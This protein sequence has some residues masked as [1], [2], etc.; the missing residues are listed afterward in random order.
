VTYWAYVADAILVAVERDDTRSRNYILHGDM[1]NFFLAIKFQAYYFRSMLIY[2]GMQPRTPFTMATFL[3]SF[4]WLLLGRQLS[5]PLLGRQLSW[6]LLGR[7]L[8]WPLL[9]RQLSWPLLWPPVSWDITYRTSGDKSYFRYLRSLGFP[10]FLPS[11]HAYPR[12]RFQYSDQTWL[13][14]PPNGA[15]KKSV[16]QYWLQ[17]L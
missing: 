10:F 8:S 15:P 16:S 14:S 4:L 9:G 1:P 12:R 5:W 7:Q 17:V 13:V 6:P 3:S 2:S 11:L